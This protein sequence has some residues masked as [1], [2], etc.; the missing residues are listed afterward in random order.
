MLIRSW[1]RGSEAEWRDWLA[2][3]DFGLPAANSAEGPLLVPTRPPCP[4]TGRRGPPC[5]TPAPAPSCCAATP[6]G[7]AAARRTFLLPPRT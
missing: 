7:Q 6:C 4:P 1:D 2:G 3:R 5:S